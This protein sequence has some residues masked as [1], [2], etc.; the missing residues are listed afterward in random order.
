MIT[1]TRTGGR[2]LRPLTLT[3]LET[4][5]AS[6]LYHADVDCKAALGR[7]TQS[8][9][10]GS[11]GIPCGPNWTPVPFHYH[12]SLDQAECCFPPAL[13]GFRNAD[14]AK[15]SPSH[16]IIWHLIFFYSSWQSKALGTNL[17]DTQ[18]NH[19]QNNFLLIGQLFYF[20]LMVGKD[21]CTL[22]TGEKKSSQLV[23]DFNIHLWNNQGWVS[24]LSLIHTYWRIESR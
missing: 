2:E 8:R 21:K 11:S 4:A 16:I 23:L 1:V 3:K 9:S 18:I 14:L 22:I 19:S 20:I 10:A 13:M 24:P 7:E 12:A 6:R 17:I 5:A 15:A